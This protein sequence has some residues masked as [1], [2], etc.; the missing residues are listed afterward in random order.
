MIDEEIY[1]AIYSHLFA[2]NH[3]VVKRQEGQVSSFMHD[4]D[5]LRTCCIA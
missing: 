5:F 2:R 4:N 1:S 3:Q